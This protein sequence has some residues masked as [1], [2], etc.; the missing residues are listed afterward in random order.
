MDFL[1]SL[2]NHPYHPLLPA[3]LV[4]ILYPCSAV[5]GWYVL[6][7]RPTLVCPCEWVHRRTS[8]MIS[9]LLLQQYS[10]YLVHLIWMVLEIGGRWQYNCCFVGCCFLDLFSTIHNI[11][12]QLPFSF[13]FIHFVSVHVV[14]PY[15]KIDTT[16]AWKKSHFYFIG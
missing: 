6:L 14:H 2:A 15:S 4:Y 3:G 1:D 7:D 12:V 10:P 13:S 11:L 5:V 16:A 9:F 8:L